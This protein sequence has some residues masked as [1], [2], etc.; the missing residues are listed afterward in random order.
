MWTVYKSS[1]IRCIFCDKAIAL[2]TEAGFKP[3]VKDI[4]MDPEAMAFFKASGRKT[5]PLIYAN[6]IKIGGLAELA[7]ILELRSAG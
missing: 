5:V 7:R 6:D 4:A 2:L 1:K 3:I